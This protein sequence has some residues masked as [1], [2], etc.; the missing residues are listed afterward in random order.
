VE[1]LI[2]DSLLHEELR[3]F[4]RR[5]FDI[6]RIATRISSGKTV[7]RD[8]QS[9]RSTLQVLP[10]IR[11]LFETNDVFFQLAGEIPDFSQEQELLETALEDEPSAIPGDGKVIRKGYNKEFDELRELLFSSREKLK[12]FELH[13]K[14]RTGISNLKVTLYYSG[15]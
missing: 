4:L 8:L 1:A 12:E 15:A 3:D 2:H 11:E 10:Y 5:V 14:R 7:P 6:E 13:E 9:L